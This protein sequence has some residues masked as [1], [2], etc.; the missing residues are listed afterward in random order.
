MSFIIFSVIPNGK[1]LDILR[2]FEDEI[3]FLCVL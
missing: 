1:A 3:Y 2:W